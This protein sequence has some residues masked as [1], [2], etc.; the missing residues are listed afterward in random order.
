MILVGVHRG[1]AE[2]EDHIV[3]QAFVRFRMPHRSSAAVLFKLGSSIE[4]EFIPQSQDS[5]AILLQVG[6]S[7][8]I[9]PAYLAWLTCQ[10]CPDLHLGIGAGPGQTRIPG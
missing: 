10:S 6:A 9:A 3:L 5:A 7:L 4:V 1:Q 2:G 8:R